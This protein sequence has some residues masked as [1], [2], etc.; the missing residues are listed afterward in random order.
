VIAVDISPVEKNVIPK[1]VLE[2]MIR[3]VN[4]F[5]MLLKCDS[6][7]VSDIGLF[8]KMSAKLG[9]IIEDH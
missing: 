3:H 5:M 4:P 8:L 2:A 7:C 6:R 9:L 1:I